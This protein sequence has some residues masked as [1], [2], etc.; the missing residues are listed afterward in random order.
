MNILIVINSFRLGGAEKLCY[1]LAL[2]LSQNPSIKVFLYSVGKVETK[3]ENE[4]FREFEKTL[5]T[6][7]S[8]N[9]PYK[10]Q[11]LH[12]AIKI[13]QFCK[14][15]RIDII[16]TNGQSPDFLARC[17]KVLGNKSKIVVT[18]H[19]T[20]GYSKKLEGFFSR[21]TEAY[22]AVSKDALRYSKVELGISK[23]VELIENGIDL[24]VYSNIKKD[25]GVFEILSVGRVQPQKDYIK[26]A[27]YLAKF[28]NQRKEVKWIIFGDCTYDE[29]Y[30][31]EFRTECK[32]LGIEDSVVFKGVV[33]NPKEIY[34]HGKIF[35][36]ASSFEGFG[37]AFIEAIMSN[38]YIF[39]R[40]V[41]VIPDILE[42]GGV[43]HNIE[44]DE[45]INILEAIYLNRYKSDELEKNKEIVGSL[46]SLDNMAEKYLGVYE[47]VLRD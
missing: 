17:S 47:K 28:L 30:V 44:Y 41:G 38:H 3:L 34:G 12:T 15:H 22:T 6:V 40:N 13:K 20:K 27:R 43:V 1:D 42:N 31:D 5:V 8:F 19:N 7:G 18:F 2:K 14:T 39:A 24:S 4:L 26:A 11:R 23:N 9:K 10:K 46:Y 35:V 33:S 25:E 36:L 37:I 32:K 29:E 21:F 16:H 45:S